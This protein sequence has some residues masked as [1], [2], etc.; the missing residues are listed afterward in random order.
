MDFPVSSGFCVSPTSS[1]ANSLDRKTR[2]PLAQTAPRCERRSGRLWLRA[3]LTAV[4]KV[5]RPLSGPFPRRSRVPRAPSR[6]WRRATG[7]SAQR[8]TGSTRKDALLS[9]GLPLKPCLD[10]EAQHQGTAPPHASISL[11]DPSGDLHEVGL[12]PSSQP[13][14]VDAST[15]AEIDPAA[16]DR[17]VAALGAAGVLPYVVLN[18]DTLV[19]DARQKS[20]RVARAR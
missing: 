9:S 17:L 19:L 12:L 18:G 8:R 15:V 14:T 7:I 16:R 2:C 4:E 20:G 1:Q 6:L 10:H 3:S 5:A 13:I 11:E